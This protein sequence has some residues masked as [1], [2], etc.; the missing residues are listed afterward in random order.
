MKTLS[1]T[2][3]EKCLVFGVHVS[4][5]WADLL[6]LRQSAQ[7]QKWRN[8]E[9][10]IYKKQ[11]FES[12]LVFTLHGRLHVWRWSFWSTVWGWG[13]CSE[14]FSDEWGWICMKFF[15]MSPLVSA[16]LSV[17]Y[18]QCVCMLNHSVVSDSL[19]PHKLEPIRLLHPWNFPGKNT[20]VGCPFLLQGIF[21]TQGLNPCLL[22]RL[23]WQVES[24]PLAPPGCLQAVPK[25]GSEVGTVAGILMWASWAQNFQWPLCLLLHPS[26][27]T[28]HSH[29]RQWVRNDLSL[30]ELSL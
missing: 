5:T 4:L 26:S 17:L 15:T 27:H 21:P 22:H 12:S 2:Q 6:T 28:S 16:Y 18:R 23:H 11:F 20:G 9:D 24:L 1:H 13:W 25:E 10:V 3:Y 7:R 19:R 29:A 14:W 30:K 8:V